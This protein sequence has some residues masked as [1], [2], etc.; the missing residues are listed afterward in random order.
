MSAANS[1]GKKSIRVKFSISPTK[2]STK[3]LTL[4][5]KNLLW[6]LINRATKAI[7]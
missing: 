6:A 5:D 2:A 7:R 4:A 3:Q 1:V